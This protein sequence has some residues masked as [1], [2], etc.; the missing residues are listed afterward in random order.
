MIEVVVKRA[1]SEEELREMF[2]LRKEVFVDEQRIFPT[3]DL[4]RNDSASI[5]LIA[6]T[7]GEI[8][9]TVRI[10]PKDV[11]AGHWVGGRLAVRNAYRRHGV[12][13]LLIQEAVRYARKCGCARFT[14]EIQAENV[15]LFSGLG[16]RALGGVEHLFGRP[17]RLMEA[18]L[19]FLEQGP[20]ESRSHRQQE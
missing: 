16:W 12:G 13:G 8:V 3:S 9:G 6:Q 20:G 10:Y 15:S 11:T 5:Y 17:H 14:A 1:V 19:D 7:G 18:P 2:F 4:D